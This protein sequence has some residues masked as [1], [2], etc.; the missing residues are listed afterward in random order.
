MPEEG[1]AEMPQEEPFFVFKIKNY[2]NK[3]MTRKESRKY[4]CSQ[5]WALRLP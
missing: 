1:A 4:E 2:Y 3:E 5:T